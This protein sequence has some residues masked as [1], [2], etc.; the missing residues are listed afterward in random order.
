MATETSRVVIPQEFTAI[1]TTAIGADEGVATFTPG[2]T[3]PRLRKLTEII[4]AAMA[5]GGGQTPAPSGTTLS[6][7]FANE[8][9]TFDADG[10]DFILATINNRGRL[11]IKGARAYVEVEGDPV[12]INNFQT[13]INAF[14][15]NRVRAL[16]PAWVLNS[17][18]PTYPAPVLSATLI[19][20]ENAIERTHLEGAVIRKSGFTK[21][22][23]VDLSERVNRA[24]TLT[25]D[26]TGLNYV[27]GTIQGWGKGVANFR[28]SLLGVRVAE[29]PP[30]NA[31]LVEVLRGDL[32]AATA[33]KFLVTD[34]NGNLAVANPAKQTETLTLQ[35]APTSTAYAPVV[36]DTIV[37][38]PFAHFV[39][40]ETGGIEFIFWVFKADG[41]AVQF[42]NLVF[43]Q[44][45]DSDNPL[46]KFSLEG[47]HLQHAVGGPGNN[48]RT[49]CDRMFLAKHT[50]YIN[51]D[52]LNVLAGDDVAGDPPANIA[53]GTRK[54]GA[55]RTKLTFTDPVDFAG[56]VTKN[57]V[58]LATAR[59]P[60]QL[61]ANLHPVSE[62]VTY[63]R[64]VFP[65]GVTLGQF[66]A[67]QIR[68]SFLP[69]DSQLASW[70]RELIINFPVQVALG[71]DSPNVPVGM[72]GAFFYVAR[73]HQYS[74][75]LGNGNYTALTADNASGLEMV[76]EDANSNGAQQNITGVASVRA[77]P[78]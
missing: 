76:L 38:E 2:S 78:L 26:T 60:V 42:D 19:E 73:F 53:L 15:D 31:T 57:G 12:D 59:A 17:P 46:G 25:G 45:A 72:R 49:P 40:A 21:S 28:N 27:T 32:E 69:H 20:L 1:A 77:I 41:S 63:A 4:A 55:G 43:R 66:S 61:S 74:Q 29:V 7:G 24:G 18:N 34:A 52:A 50:G 9:P 22:V 71:D 30:A 13:E 14:A 23:Q 54:Q 51:H 48:A 56:E 5:A 39:G 44:A 68:F 37:C 3:N 65:S 8:A 11:F 47:P 36:G 62:N 67:I 6:L 64:L 70:A 33:I 16:V 75:S 35:Q 58:A 10:A